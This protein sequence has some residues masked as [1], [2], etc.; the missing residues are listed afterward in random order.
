MAYSPPSLKVY[1]EFVPQLAGNTLPLYACIIAPQ[2]GLHRYTEEDEKALLGAYDKDSGNTFTS[3]PDKTAGSTVDVSSSQIMV[4]D[5]ILEY[6]NFTLSGAAGV[7]GWNGLLTDGGNKIR[8]ESLIFRTANGENRSSVYGTRDV[9]LG[10]YIKVQYGA[11]IVETTVS[12]VESEE[13]PAA[14]GTLAAASTNQAAIGSASAVVT[15]NIASGEF[16]VTA[17][18]AAYS[19]IADGDAEEVYTVVVTSTDGTVDNT[20]VSV[21]SASG[22]DDCA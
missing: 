5:G 1:Q 17:S 14:V 18:A 3:W 16:G 8:S 15:E 11:E 4:E 7:T 13:D 2:Y 12:G 21:T 6:Y 20:V 10:D 22:N 19:G 9:A